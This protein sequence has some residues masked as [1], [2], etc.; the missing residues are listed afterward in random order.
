[1]SPALLRLPIKNGGLKGG[2]N[3]AGYPVRDEEKSVH[4]A[5][6]SPNLCFRTGFFTC[7]GCTLTSL[8]PELR[9]WLFP[10]AREVGKRHAK[11]VELRFIH[12][13]L[14]LSFETVLIPEQIAIGAQQGP[15]H[16]DWESLAV[17]GCVAS[18]GRRGGW[19]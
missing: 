16:G 6:G 18:S 13:I 15:R 10:F 9:N 4:T 7:S 19:R 14:E 8:E 17:F 1:M 5:G 11:R 3:L 2:L 12:P